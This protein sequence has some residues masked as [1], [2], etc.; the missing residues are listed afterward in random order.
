M[1]EL[2]GYLFMRKDFI[3][4]CWRVYPTSWLSIYVRGNTSLNP[5]LDWSDFCTRIRILT[6]KKRKVFLR[7]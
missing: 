4:I 7:S 5:N 1:D 6:R 2:C 3:G